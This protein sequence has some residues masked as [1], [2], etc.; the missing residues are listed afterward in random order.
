[1]YIIEPQFSVVLDFCVKRNK[2]YLEFGRM[3]NTHHILTWQVH[4]S[5]E[6]RIRKV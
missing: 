6:R 2:M 4:F 1:M 3:I 5:L